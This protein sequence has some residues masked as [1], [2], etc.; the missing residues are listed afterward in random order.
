MKIDYAFI[1]ENLGFILREIKEQPEV[2]LH[3]PPDCI[4]YDEQVHQ[5]GEWLRDSGEYGLVYES[6][7]SALE[8]FPFKLSG[9]AAIKLLEVGLIFGFKTESEADR[10]FDRR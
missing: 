7:V 10:K 8:K 4:S 2:A 3:F 5:V 1:E 6:I 9:R